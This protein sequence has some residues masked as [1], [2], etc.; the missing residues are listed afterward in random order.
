LLN[1]SDWNDGWLLS[2]MVH[3]LGASIPG[4]PNIDRTKKEQ[5]CQRALDACKQ[6]RIEIY[7]SAKELSDP[8]VESIGVMATIIQ[9]KYAK[10]IKTANERAKI[11]LIEQ[12]TNVVG[13]PV[14]K[15]HNFFTLFA[16]F[17]FNRFQRNL[18]SL[19]FFKHI[20]FK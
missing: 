3:K 17:K 10:A 4:Y 19:I 11:Y 12:D 13:K 8:E 20:E 9:L 6:L 14:R 1:K 7:V 5:N 15:E 18:E 2:K 16:N